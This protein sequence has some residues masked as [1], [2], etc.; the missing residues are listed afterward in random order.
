MK[1]GFILLLI[2][3]VLAMGCSVFFAS[4]DFLE[5]LIK[6]STEEGPVE[7]D[8]PVTAKIADDYNYSA[9]AGNII[10]LA[11]PN[12]V[13]VKLH[14]HTSY[15]GYGEE[16]FY[17]AVGIKGDIYY[18][19]DKKYENYYDLSYEKKAI[20]YKNTGVGWK[21]E[22]VEYGSFINKTTVTQMA[23]AGAR[24]VYFSFYRFVLE[25]DFA[26][27]ST[28]TVAGRECDKYVVTGN[29]NRG[30]YS[31]EFCIDKETG[32]CLK[33]VT[34]GDVPGD[35]E[36]YNFECVEFNTE[37]TPTLPTVI[38]YIPPGNY[39][40]IYFSD[41]EIDQEIDL[42]ACSQVVYTEK[43][44]T[45][46]SDYFLLYDLQGKAITDYSAQTGIYV[47]K[48]LHNEIRKLIINGYFER[49]VNLLK[50]NKEM[51]ECLN[52]ELVQYALNHT[53]DGSYKT[54]LESVETSQALI[55]SRYLTLLIAGQLIDQG[56]VQYA[57]EDID[58][59]NAY[60]EIT[61]Y[62]YGRNDSAEPSQTM[63]TLVEAVVA[64]KGTEEE[65]YACVIE[66]LGALGYADKIL[67]GR[68][69]EEVADSIRLGTI[70][71]E[72]YA[73][74]KTEV[75]AFM[76]ANG[77]ADMESATPFALLQSATSLV[78]YYVD[79]NNNKGSLPVL[80][81]FEIQGTESDDQ[82]AASYLIDSSFM[83]A[84]ATLVSSEE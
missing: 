69:D 40:G 7:E 82:P 22:D 52:N 57:G 13:F 48:K 64:Q 56:K 84:H 9:V 83:D 62:W 79:K 27:K 42:I 16:D 58:F 68:E 36:S 21:K 5:G 51:E 3:I 37:Y 23:T 75:N 74:V 53:D 4:C 65:K 45:T 38:G 26:V 33:H 46:Y 19:L 80:G 24:S 15:S 12:G 49:M 18:D 1:K 35:N 14:V 30:D 2:A 77:Y 47:T 6:D 43:T 25:E 41:S 70:S 73:S 39:D 8:P 54:I 50:S 34:T 61:D 66:L 29:T 67:P 78:I 11:S 32:A 44:L 17:E 76:V 55:L 63:W 72:E 31:E 71:S 60:I 28:A 81:Y 20:R 59:F 10:G